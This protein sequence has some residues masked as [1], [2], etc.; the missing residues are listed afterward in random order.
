[1]SLAAIDVESGKVKSL[2][3][4]IW[5]MDDAVWSPDGR[6]VFI[7][8]QDASTR[9]HRQIAYSEYPSGT[10]HRITND[11]NSY[12]SLSATAD[13]KTLVAVSRDIPTQL[14]VMPV[15]G[16]SEATAQA[17][18]IS[19]GREEISSLNWTLDG[20]LLVGNRSFEFSLRGADGSERR[21]IFSDG[22]H[23]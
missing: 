15:A 13:A 21:S 9:Y 17:E 3:Q 23:A 8:P 5:G 18:Q 12:R 2:P 7:T 16:T 19:S 6:G 22:S 10:I 4:N 1:G 20:R 14:W 11:F